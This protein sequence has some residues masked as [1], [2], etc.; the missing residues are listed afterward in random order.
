MQIHL[1]NVFEK[2]LATG[3]ELG[4]RIVGAVI[5]FIVGKFIVNWINKILAKVLE[6]RHIEPGVQTFVRSL[7]NILL[8]LLLALAILGNLGVELTA[9]A[10]LLASAGVAVGMAL[11]GHLQNFAGGLIILVFRP[12][13]VGDYIESDAGA[14]GK[15]LEIQIFHT[16]LLTP[17]NKVVFAPNGTMSNAVCVNYNKM[18]T[19][20]VDFSFGFEY[21][22]D[23]KRVEKVLHD[24]ISADKRI[25]A[26]PK[27][28][29]ELGA[30]ADSS[31]NVTVRVWVKTADYWDVFFSM[32]Q[33]VYS[34][35][36]KENISIPYPQ[37]VVHNAK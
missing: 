13:R 15:V 35:F 29:V 33:A 6:R 20:R 11:S 25:L 22:E 19:R 26:D 8:M 5:I 16:V 21:G 18:D 14:S 1:E 17:D 3:T 28:F 37:L 31:V 9:F 34:T 24:I 4:T 2:L 30:L 12:Y 7:S 10:A 36:N 23:Y 27:P 32:N